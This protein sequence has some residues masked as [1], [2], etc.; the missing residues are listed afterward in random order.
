M[1]GLRFGGHIRF[2]HRMGTSQAFRTEREQVPDQVAVISGVPYRHL[3]FYYYYSNF[4]VYGGAGSGKTKSI[5][6]W[7]LEEYIRL[8]F[9]GFIYDFKDVDYTQTAYNLTK[10]YGYPHKFYYVSFDKPERSYRFN[11]LKVVKD[12]TELMQLMDP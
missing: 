4:L 9:A 12:R 5:G 11:P 7:L 6:K 3:E 10:K 8:G 1:A 2:L